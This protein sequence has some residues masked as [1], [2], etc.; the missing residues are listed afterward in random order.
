MNILPDTTEKEK[1]SVIIPTYNSEKYIIESIQSVLNQ[2][3]TN[4]EIIVIDDGSTDKTGELIS[5]L[6]KENIRYIRTENQG[7][8][9]ARN[10][11]IIESKGEFI[12]F[13]DSDDIWL[14]NKLDKQIDLIRNNPDI[15]F[16]STGFTIFFDQNPEQH[17]L[18]YNYYCKHDVTD[19]TKFI[20]LLL[21]NNFVATSSL[22]IRKE[23]IDK[24]GLFDTK[25]QNAMDYDFVLRLAG[26][27][28][29]IYLCEPLISRREHNNNI[30]K[31]RINTYR[32]LIYIYSKLKSNLRSLEQYSF[33]SES[34]IQELINESMYNLGLDALLI[35][36]Y[37]TAYESLKNSNKCSKPLFKFIAM[38]SAKW[39]LNYL[40]KFIKYYRKFIQTRNLKSMPI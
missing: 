24:I 32:A 37:D 19:F 31:N 11:G 3:Y 22:I 18:D 21:R 26:H 34:E 17:Y 2:T 4:I 14:E 36:D 33:I 13:L 1:V 35:F 29:A 40:I 39:H 30:S 8:Y 23:C 12:A 25:F 10:R 16:C 9:F 5:S 38:Q 28:K 20:N 6:K 15:G 7:N 27:Y